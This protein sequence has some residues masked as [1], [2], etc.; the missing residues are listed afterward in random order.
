MMIIIIAGGRAPPPL[1]PRSSLPKTSASRHAVARSICVIPLGAWP[2]P[3]CACR[4]TRKGLQ[5]IQIMDYPLKSAIKCTCNPN[6]I[7]PLISGIKCTSETDK[8]I[9]I[10]AAR[11]ASHGRP[12]D[13]SE[14]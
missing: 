7:L 2:C 3:C 12:A 10:S 14:S 1:V 4:V 6:H 11:A 9:C 8:N 5:V 13:L